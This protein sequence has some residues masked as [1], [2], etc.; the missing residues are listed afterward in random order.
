MS[1]ILG[2]LSIGL[3]LLLI[4]CGGGGA[5]NSFTSGGTTAAP[6]SPPV[7]QV[8]LTR[9]STDTFTN[10]SSQ[11][12]SEVEPHAFAVG[13]T[14][15]SAFQVGRIFGGG[16]AAIGFATST[17][18]G[19]TWTSGFLPGL[20]TSQ[21]GGPFSAASDAAV[22]F[23]SKHAVWLIS[24]LA[25]TS[26]DRVVVSRSSDG[27]TWQNPI[28][29]STTPNADKN[30]TV[31]DNTPTSPHFG[32]CYME[33]DDPSQAGLI[34]M[35]TSTDGGL[36]W[37]AAATTADQAKGIGGIP[38]VQPN[39]NVIVPISSFSTQANPVANQMSFRSTD[40]GSTW[41]SITIISPISDH[42]EA[43]SVRST[44]LPTAHV[45]ATG[46]IYVA[47]HDC[48]FRASCVSNDIVMSTS[49][50]GLTWTSPIRVPLDTT[51]STVDHFLPALAIDPATA[52]ASAH[53]ALLYY[54]YPV[55]SCT[56][57][58]CSLNVG[59]VTSQDGGASWSS[60]TTLV[61][62]MSL[63]SLPNTSSGRMVGDYFANVFSN[64]KA[65]PIFAVA[66]LPTGTT[67]DQAIYAPVTGFNALIANRIFVS[68]TQRAVPN[69]KSDHA[70]SAYYDLDREHPQRPP[71]LRKMLKR[72]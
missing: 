33:W 41:S 37:S 47:W 10:S 48:R 6:P 50:D 70:P 64:A 20:T 15:V 67:L 69:A 53:L 21:G 12:A 65:L 31:C 2:F 52:G 26:S 71:Q 25:I 9:L 36:T 5:G 43:G 59:F 44:P 68:R 19:A 7:Q 34:F 29:V 49:P 27:L 22:A 23:D 4:S 62:G 24:T 11:H 40:G 63:S 58:T 42:A 17:N 39:G 14:I 51:S 35:S 60:P 32:N 30:W 46:N 16:G 13:S 56:T 1:R 54:F 57:D 72:K 8:S 38:L 55:S 28:T 3:I 45:D 66:N 61:S 18:G